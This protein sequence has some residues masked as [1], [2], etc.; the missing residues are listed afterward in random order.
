L[1]QLLDNKSFTILYTLF[2]NRYKVVITVL[3][4][5]KANV[6][7]LFNIKYTKKISEFLNTLLK[8]LERPVSVK[9]Y[10]RQIEKPIISILQIYLQVDRQ[11][12]YNVSFLVIDLEYYNIIFNCK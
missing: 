2:C 5:S 8:T 7:V 10:N 3:A 9:G 11:Q 6:F 12:Q 1:S 4:N